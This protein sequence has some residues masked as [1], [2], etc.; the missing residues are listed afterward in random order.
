MTTSAR[1]PTTG[2]AF[3][4]RAL[5]ISMSDDYLAIQLEDGRRIEV[6][7]AWFP[8]L[9]Q[10]SPEQRNNWRLLGHGVGIHW[11]DVDEDISVANLLGSD[12]ERLMYQDEPR[13]TLPAK[14]GKVVRGP[15]RIV[16]SRAHT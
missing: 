16:A 12:G 8:R 9:A 15:D 13:P 4:A 7:L 2:P 10:A 11:P 1:K 5:Q 3:S 14:V 6:P